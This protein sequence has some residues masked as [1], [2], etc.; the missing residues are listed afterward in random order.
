MPSTP[1]TIERALRFLLP[2]ALLAFAPALAQ[3]ADPALGQVT[4]VAGSVTAQQPGGPLRTLS[5]GDDV[6]AGDTIVTSEGARVGMLLGDVLAHAPE[7]G[8]LTLAR[9][10][11]GEPD[12]TL[13]EGRVRLIDPREAGP[14]ARLAALDTEAAVAGNDV[15]A[16]VLSEKVGPYAMFC[17]WDEPLD[18]ARGDERLTAAPGECVIAKRTEPLYAARAHDQ[19]IAA[20]PAEECAVDPNIL[21]SLAGDPARHLDPAAV[22]A[23]PPVV[24]AGNA[25]LGALNPAGASL[26]PVNAC[27]S[28]ASG[29]GVFPLA[30]VGLVEPPAVGGGGPGSGGPFIP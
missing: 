27:D 16:Y 20:A 30:P 12:V 11:A 26:G 9:N 24:T 19:R 18:T 25:G 17:E 23:P 10:A 28:P 5:C 1:R 14:A 2:I 13:E 15:E 8:R 7:K 6:F 22:S 21:A 29:C 4:S 3:A